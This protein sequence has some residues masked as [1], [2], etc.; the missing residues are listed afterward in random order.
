MLAFIAHLLQDALSEKNV[1]KTS[2]CANATHVKRCHNV[3]AEFDKACASPNRTLR[4]RY[5]NMVMIIKR[6]THAELNVHAH[7]RNT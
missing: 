2:A 4:L 6:Y 7:G 3:M 5:M 1:E